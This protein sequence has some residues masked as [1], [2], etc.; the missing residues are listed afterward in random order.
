MSDIGYHLFDTAIGR[1]GVAW[2]AARIVAATLPEASEDLAIARLQRRTPDAQPSEPPV[3][4]QATIDRIVALLDGKAID[5]SDTPLDMTGIPPFHRRVY[6]VAL[7]ISPG[8]TLSYGDIAT[9]L[10]EPGAARAVGQALGANPFPIIV[11]CHR[12]LAAG[13]KTGGFS[14]QGGVSTKLRMLEIEGALS[15]RATLLFDH[16]PLQAPPASRR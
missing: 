15:D 8:Q 9:R 10:G 14:A 5:L 7:T 11:P 13:R 16:L 4:V 1:C 2:H 3:P 6:A 12:V